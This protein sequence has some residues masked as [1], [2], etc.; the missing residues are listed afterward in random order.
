MGKN[1]R[2]I[3]AGIYL[4]AQPRFLVVNM[5]FVS[6]VIY[7]VQSC[8]QSLPI[9]FYLICLHVCKIVSKVRFLLLTRYWLNNE[10]IIRVELLSVQFS[11]VLM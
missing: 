5:A 10:R 11:A 2:R 3:P 1:C 6:P 8:M 9:Q 7:S 4:A